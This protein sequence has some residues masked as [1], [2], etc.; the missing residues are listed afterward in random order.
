MQRVKSSRFAVLTRRGSGLFSLAGRETGTS[1]EVHGNAGCISGR[2]R[3]P[4]EARVR[5]R[6]RRIKSSPSVLQSHLQG[7]GLF[8]LPGWKTGPSLEVHKIA[9]QFWAS[10][11]SEL[12][13]KGLMP[14]AST[15]SSHPDQV[16]QF[17]TNTLRPSLPD[18][19]TVFC[20][21]AFAGLFGFLS[22][23]DSSKLPLISYKPNPSACF[24]NRNHCLSM[25]AAGQPKKSD[26]LVRS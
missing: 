2:R 4:S 6:T 11:R 16:F 20:G 23:H 9:Q 7:S 17:Q 1:P 18:S 21:S 15:K 25:A 19:A 22:C 24:S 8:S 13:P 26:H 5:R 12:V 3:R 10:S 14:K